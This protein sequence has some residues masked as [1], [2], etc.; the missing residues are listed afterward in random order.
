VKRAEEGSRH[1]GGIVSMGDCLLDDL[2]LLSRDDL[3]R[4]EVVV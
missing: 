2:E 4:E 1:H 3:R